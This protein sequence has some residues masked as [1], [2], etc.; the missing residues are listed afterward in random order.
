MIERFFI[1]ILF[2]QIYIENPKKTKQHDK[3]R[4]QGGRIDY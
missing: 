4:R 3:I 1:Y 2:I